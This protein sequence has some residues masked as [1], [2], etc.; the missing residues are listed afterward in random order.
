MR[1]ITLVNAPDRSRAWMLGDDAPSRVVFASF[2]SVI[3]HTFERLEEDVER[4]IVD[5]TA[6]ADEFLELLAHVSEDF[7]GDV[8]LIRK[9]DT[10]YLSAKGRGAG[11]LLYALRAHDLRFYLETHGLVAAP[12]V[13]AA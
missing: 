10:A 11:R 12:S 13:A 5:R 2:L 9:G 4:I 7:A 6:T 8:I 3:R 1:R